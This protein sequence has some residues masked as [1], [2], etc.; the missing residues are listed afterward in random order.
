MDGDAM[1]E[2]RRRVVGAR[3]GGKAMAGVDGGND[4]CTS[5]FHFALTPFYLGK[6][7]L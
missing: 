1:V 5:S 4:C 2:L 3:C 7:I 6:L